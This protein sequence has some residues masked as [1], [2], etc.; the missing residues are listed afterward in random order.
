MWTVVKIDGWRRHSAPQHST[1]WLEDRFDRKLWLCMC[2]RAAVDCLLW[3]CMYLI[4]TILFSSSLDSATLSLSLLSTTKMRP[5]MQRAKQVVSKRQE[6][7]HLI[8]LTFHWVNQCVVCAT[9][10]MLS[11]RDGKLEESCGTGSYFYNL[12]ELM[13]VH[14][15]GNRTVCILLQGRK[16]IYASYGLPYGIR[17]IELQSSDYRV[18]F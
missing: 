14:H 3:Y 2:A 8:S 4:P 5:W 12:W 18:F 11:T 10:T 16:H 7:F 1:I 13:P 15:R 17:L 6:I 9:Y